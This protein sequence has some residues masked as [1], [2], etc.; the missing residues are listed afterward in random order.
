LFRFATIFH[1][2]SEVSA[3]VRFLSTAIDLRL[4]QIRVVHLHA[5]PGASLRGHWQRSDAR[6]TSTHP[7]RATNA[8]LHTDRGAM[9]A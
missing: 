3:A 5:A 9:F 4:T 6:Q 8:S 7:N 1:N 2:Q